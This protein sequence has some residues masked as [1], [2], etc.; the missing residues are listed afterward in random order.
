[1]KSIASKSYA[2]AQ[3]ATCIV[4]KLLDRTTLY[5][6]IAATLTQEKPLNSA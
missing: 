6:R 5:D 1:M 4:P 3:V 2:S